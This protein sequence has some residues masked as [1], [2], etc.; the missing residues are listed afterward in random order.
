MYLALLSEYTASISLKKRL[1]FVIEM[2]CSLWGR[3]VINLL[4]SSNVY[5]KCYASTELLVRM[6]V[7]WAVA[8]GSRATEIPTFPKERAAFNFKGQGVRTL[9]MKAVDSFETSG[10]S[11]SATQR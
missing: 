11:N 3:N 5:E 7:F 2:E 8:L 9:K 4:Q 6:Q 10:I 1:V